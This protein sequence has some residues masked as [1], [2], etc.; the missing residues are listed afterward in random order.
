MN[1]AQVR[2]ISESQASRET[3]REREETGNNKLKVRQQEVHPAQQ[4]SDRH[5]P[6]AFCF[7]FKLS[8]KIT[9]NKLPSLLRCEENKH[10]V[11]LESRPLFTQV[12]NL[13]HWVLFNPLRLRRF[14]S[15]TW[16]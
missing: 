12:C 4:E 15:G 13:R 14:G 3:D 5:T 10:E 6:S 2:P 11:E 9:S 8:S 7:V 1:K 16:L